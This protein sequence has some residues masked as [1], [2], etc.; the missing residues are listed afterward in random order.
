ME[1]W[2]RTLKDKYDM[3]VGVIDCGLGNIG[4]VRKMCD[5]AGGNTYIA[6]TPKDL[7]AAERII[8]PGVGAFDEGMNRLQE[9]GL[10]DGILSFAKE[11]K[12]PI[13]GICLG[14]QMLGLGSEEGSQAGLG[15]IQ[16]TC[17][18]FNFN[19]IGLKVPHMGWDNIN[20]EITHPL[21]RSV[22]NLSRYYFVHSYYMECS[23]QENVLAT[24]SYGAKFTVAVANHNV[25]GVQFHPEKSHK[26]GLALFKDFMRWEL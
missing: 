14:M 25:S 1:S 2:R 26:Y 18:K 3:N 16:S 22:T 10:K 24:C 23:S 12:K 19:E 9:S 17:V 5:M 8:L 20:R 21:L 13:L 15:L 6:R 4:S 11:K 7:E